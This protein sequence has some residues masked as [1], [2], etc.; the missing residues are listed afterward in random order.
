MLYVE[1]R[2]DIMKNERRLIHKSVDS[3]Y[4]F[5]SHSDNHYGMRLA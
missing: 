3:D 4:V 1:Y 2:Q 5:I